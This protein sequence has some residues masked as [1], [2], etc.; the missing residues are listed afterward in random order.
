MYLQSGGIP[1]TIVLGHGDGQSAP[2]LSGVL[3]TIV[4][5]DI[6]FH[7]TI[8]NKP[9][10]NKILDFIFDSVGSFV[11]PNSI[12][13]MLKNEG[14]I[15]D[16]KTI[17]QYLDYLVSAFLIYRVPRYDIKGKNLLRSLDKYYMVDTGFR[18]IRLPQ[19]PD[20]NVGHI[21]E[22]VVYLELRRRF[23]KVFVGKL[24]N[25]EVDF[26]V[27]DYKGYIAYYQ[28]AFTTIEPSTLE[29]ELAPL[30]AIRDSNPKFLLTA[31][32]DINPIYDGIRKLN[33]AEWLLGN[34]KPRWQ[35]NAF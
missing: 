29:R 33:V 25:G 18:R 19:K 9:T 23:P 14:I 1:Q 5:K 15:I 20:A 32:I 6:F 24:R 4:E 28:V 30:R 21:L 17:A 13:G 16:H 7:H 2:L 35:V 27:M 11:S 22:N 12:S 8:H 26:V 10:F 31:D 34:E 3:G